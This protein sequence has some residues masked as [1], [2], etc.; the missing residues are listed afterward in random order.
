MRSEPKPYSLTGID[1]V[2][3]SLFISTERQIFHL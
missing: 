1:L 2:D 3:F